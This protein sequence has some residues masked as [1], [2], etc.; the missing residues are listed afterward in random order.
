MPSRSVQFFKQTSENVN[1]VS[2]I[3]KVRQNDRK[4]LKIFEDFSIT[5]ILR[6]IDFC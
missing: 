2:K 3:E 5:D 4:I 1:K 6:E